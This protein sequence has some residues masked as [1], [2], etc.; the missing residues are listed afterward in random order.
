MCIDYVGNRPDQ[1]APSGG[2]QVSGSFI[3]T[4]GVQQL[5]FDTAGQAL[6]SEVQQQ[7]ILPNLNI[8]KQKRAGSL[9]LLH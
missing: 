4:L 7:P 1:W 9:G 6:R 3:Y 8:Y 2:N 5:H